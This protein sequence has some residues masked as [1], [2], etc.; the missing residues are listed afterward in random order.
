MNI[1]GP[2]FWNNLPATIREATSLCS[3]KN[4]LKKS[5]LDRTE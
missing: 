5:I 3:F 1:R 2:H 4:S